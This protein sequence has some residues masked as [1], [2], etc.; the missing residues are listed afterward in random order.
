[1]ILEEE[2]E[3]QDDDDEVE[4]EDEQKMY[5]AD[6]GEDDGSWN[7]IPTNS[8][9]SPVGHVAVGASM[10]PLSAALPP[11][12]A[13]ASSLSGDPSP[14]PGPAAVPHDRRADLKADEDAVMP[15]DDE[16]DESAGPKQPPGKVMGSALVYG[17]LGAD[18]S[19]ADE[20]DDDDGDHDDG[21]PETSSP[22]PP[23]RAPP[24]AVAT[25]ALSTSAMLSSAATSAP[26]SSLPLPT[27]AV[28]Q[29]NTLAA[30]A[31]V[32]AP[33]HVNPT[34]LSAASKLPV[35][36]ADVS[37]DEWDLANQKV[38]EVGLKLHE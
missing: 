9:D 30:A 8:E 33:G 36:T 4:E 17:G 19:D 25:A 35:T 21:K 20:S 31:A 24:A 7:N 6:N 32:V 34:N 29:S 26:S 2:E 22:D 3:E 10:P 18:L 11:T 15:F 1:V 37:V 13:P 23:A 16:A 12:S 5:L 27:P 14:A 28:L 38:L